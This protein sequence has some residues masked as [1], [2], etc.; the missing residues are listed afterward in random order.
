MPAATRALSALTV[1][2]ALAG[3]SGSDDS[4]RELSDV[5]RPSVVAKIDTGQPVGLSAGFGSVWV[6]DHREETVSRIDPSTNRVTRSIRL[7]V[8]PADLAAGLGGV[9]VPVLEGFRLARVDPRTN[10][11]TASFPGI[12]TQAITGAGSVWAL[13]FEEGTRDWGGDW[14]GRT[15][16]RIDP[17]TNKIV[18]RIRFR[19]VLGNVG[20]AFG[21]GAVWVATGQRSIAR[22]DPDANQAVARIAVNGVPETLAVGEGAVWAALSDGRVARIDPD[23]NRVVATI[24]TGTYLNY[25]AV[26]AGAV[27][28]GNVNDIVNSTLSKIDPTTNRVV[29]TISICDGPQGLLVAFG[30]VWVGCFES[31]QVWRLRP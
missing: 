22:I 16:V 24:R 1:L 18:A 23:R 7:G 21:E 12:F 28:A 31:S 26:G 5:R 29:S 19:N 2:L 15:V 13:H 14:K 25:V 6:A 30:D 4:A 27:W 11:E 9:W 8:F 10:R 20:I 17:R 3:C